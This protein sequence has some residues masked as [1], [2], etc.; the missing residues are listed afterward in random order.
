MLLARERA[1]HPDNLIPEYL[2]DLRDFLIIFAT[3][4][5]QQFS[6]YKRNNS[7]R[8]DKL[9]DAPHDG[10]YYYYCRAELL[11]HSALLKF[12]FQE[13]NSAA[14]EMN[15][16]YR[17]LGNCTDKYPRFLPAYKDLLMLKAAIG[18]APSGYKWVISI[19]GFSGDL[20][21]SMAQ[22]ANLLPKLEKSREY[23]LFLNESRI[24]YGYLCYYLMNDGITA[25][26]MI[27]KATTG[28][29]NSPFMS[30]V[31]GNLALRVKKTEEAIEA[32]KA[33][34]ADEPKIPYLDYFYGMAKLQ[35][36]DRDGGYYIARF[37]RRFQGKNYIKDAY[38]K[39]GWAFLLIGD[40]GNYQRSMSLVAEYG[41]VQ[42]EE[43]KN[44]L[45][46]AKRPYA[47][48]LPLLRARLYYDGGYYY[49]ALDELKPC[50]E[51]TFTQQDE[52]AEYYYRYGRI[53]ESVKSYPEALINYGL[54]VKYYSNTNT[55]FAPAACLYM[56]MIYEKQQDYGKAKE[57][58]KL[59][60]S[61]KSYI[62]KDAFDQKAKA[63]LKRIE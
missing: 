24:V 56:G 44:A 26:Q 43:D 38:L 60:E 40:K 46:E 31:R 52:K 6:E 59:C 49:K 39:L 14:Y 15:K 16:A 18:T 50:K 5:E 12:K 48:S 37:L 30:F 33:Q 42:L 3:E 45:R 58:Y 7:A 61:Y 34:V 1:V 55:Y 51:S 19:L 36:G 57:Y 8:L 54:V 29:A 20:K 4:D 62:Y 47:P 2:E 22:Y 23:N 25:W 32:M 17:A 9:N 11:M 28:Y 27:D 35:R 21:A 41:A 10:P 13:T 63:G 53:C